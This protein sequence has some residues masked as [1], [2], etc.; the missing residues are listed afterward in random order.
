MYND[1]V[2]IILS[3]LKREG[4]EKLPYK[5]D[6][7]SLLAAAE[8]DPMN[9]AGAWTR[10]QKSRLYQKQ[11]VQYCRIL[12]YINEMNEQKYKKGWY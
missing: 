5:K 6:I 10:L 2:E 3:D 12:E 1:T 4:F 7:L 9:E 8:D 11:S